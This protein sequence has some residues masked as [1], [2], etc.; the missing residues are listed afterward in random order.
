MCRTLGHFKLW[1]D[2]AGEQ[3]ISIRNRLLILSV[4]RK[5]GSVLTSYEYINSSHIFSLPILQ[6]LFILTYNV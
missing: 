3:V 6:N 5:L 4:I 1:R 2:F